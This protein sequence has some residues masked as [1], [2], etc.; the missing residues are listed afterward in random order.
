M[1]WRWNSRSSRAAL[2]LSFSLRL[3]VGSSRISSSTV[4]GQRLGDLDQ[5]LLADAE[6]GDQRRR[7]ISSGPT[8]ASSAFALCGTGPSR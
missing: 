4:L 6:I 5:L 8:W 2:A 1:P 7:A 3:A